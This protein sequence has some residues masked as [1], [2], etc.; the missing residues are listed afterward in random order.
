MGCYE[1]GSLRMESRVVVSLYGPFGVYGK[2]FAV[3]DRVL[4][5][6]RGFCTGGNAVV[7][8]YVC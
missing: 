6:K 2:A 7:D 8:Y 3:F 1:S 5:L 4:S